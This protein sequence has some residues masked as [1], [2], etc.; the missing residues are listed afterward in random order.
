MKHLIIKSLLSKK[1]NPAAKQLLVANGFVLLMVINA[2]TQDC[3][4]GTYAAPPTNI[5]IL[6]KFYITVRPWVS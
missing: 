3:I 2:A 5:E 6:K 1:F 4:A